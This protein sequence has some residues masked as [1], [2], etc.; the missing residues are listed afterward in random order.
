MGTKAVCME[1]LTEDT[2]DCSQNPISVEAEHVENYS[3]DEFRRAV[4]ILRMLIKWRDEDLENGKN[5][6]K[7]CMGIDSC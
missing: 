6:I 4:D 7:S 5:H 3:A 1:P 2:Q